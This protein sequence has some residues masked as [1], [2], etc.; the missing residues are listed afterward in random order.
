MKHPLKRLALMLLPI[1][2][3]TEAPC[4]E[5]PPAYP[6]PGHPQALPPLP[7]PSQFRWHQQEL[8]AFIHFGLNTFTG[9]EWG[10]GTESPDLFDP[11]AL[12]CEQWARTAKECGFT[13][14]TLSAKHHDGFCLWPSQ[15]TDY[16][17]KSSRWRNGAGDVVGEF[18]A[19]CRKYGLGVGIYLSPWDRHDRRYGTPAYNDYYIQQINE[20]FDRY[21]KIDSFWL[22][23]AFKDQ[24][25]S[26][27]FDWQRI[28]DAVYRRN[29]AATIEMG[30]PDVGWIGNEAGS[31]LETC[32]N[33]FEVP[34]A[35][36]SAAL[37][38]KMPVAYTGHIQ[39]EAENA[40]KHPN[41]KAIPALRYCPRLGDASV[42]EGWFWKPGQSR[43]ADWWKQ[44]YF[45]CIGRGSS[46]MYGFAPD[47]TGRFPDED[48]ACAVALK[49]ML[50]RTYAADFAAGKTPDATST[51]QGAAGYGPENATDSNPLTYWSAAE[52]QTAAT[53]EI[54]LG[55]PVAF[56]VVNLQEP[57]FMGQR[58][59]KYRVEYL[60]GT[61]WKPFSE[62][63]TIG[64][65][66]LDRRATV[67]ARKVRLTIEDARAYPLIATFGLH[68]TP[69]TV[70]G[71]DP[72]KTGTPEEKAI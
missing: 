40:G 19:A 36:T 34:Y 38:G 59:K 23:L 51:W 7:T 12:D 1:L 68:L 21:G 42:R 14:M 67:T 52:N 72:R 6:G 62:G 5:P 53:L 15:F 65:R 55:K 44:T 28:Y 30:G 57:V 3:T 63:T 49:E 45:N 69:F 56:N 25:Y 10:E 32:W 39:P 8:Q 2:P 41:Y 16:S 18:V 54:Y 22:D 35:T 61:D 66:K 27:P 20:L 4:A 29:P 33:F 48:V 50:D 64:H 71:D 46:M 60:D 13:R 24:G 70:K 9:A 47:R 17:V 26:M 31:G 37:P 11:S 58:V 43:G